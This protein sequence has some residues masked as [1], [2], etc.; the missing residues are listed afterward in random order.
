MAFPYREITHAFDELPL[1]GGFT[2]WRKDD[3]TYAAHAAGTATVR[4]YGEHGWEVTDIAVQSHRR[5]KGAEPYWVSSETYLQP[6]H[7][8][9]V[10]IKAAL[11]GPARKQVADTI[12]EARSGFSIRPGKAA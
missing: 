4:D 10:L 2:D 9:F 6:T 11:E 8:L 1:F 12:S 5:G 7:P 3:W